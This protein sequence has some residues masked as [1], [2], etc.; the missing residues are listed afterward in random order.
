MEQFKVNNFLK[1][2]TNAFPVFSQLS[3]SE[4]Q[5]IRCRL[6]GALGIKDSRESLAIVSELSNRQV[7]YP[8]ANA[9]SGEFKLQ[10]TLRSLG[11]IAE[12]NILI[13]WH[14]F[15]SITRMECAD[16]SKYFSD[17]WYPSSDDIDVFDSSLKWVVSIRHDGCVFYNFFP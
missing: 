5:A 14:R 4:C 3:P 8:D 1:S 2:S 6:E 13:N 16:L 11:V 17:I 15:D 7:A 12:T 10:E 9:D